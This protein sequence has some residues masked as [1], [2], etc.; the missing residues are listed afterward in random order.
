MSEELKPC[1]FCGP[2]QSV[3]SLWYDDAS[4]A[5]RVGCGRC[6]VST[7]IRPRSEER[8]AANAIA[9]WNRRASPIPEGGEELLPLIEEYAL[10]KAIMTLKAERGEVDDSYRATSQQASDAYRKICDLLL[11]SPRVEDVRRLR[12][13]LEW[14]MPLAA[15]A[16]ENHRMERCKYK[17]TMTYTKRNG[18]EWVGLY[19]DEY[20]KLMS[21]YDALSLLVE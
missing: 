17:H 16:L 12:E 5:Q 18:E 13:A 4:K 7:G 20:D 6:G 15:I 10:A 9:A 1:P 19:Q 3:V 14:A 8:T 11:S 2:G 21:A